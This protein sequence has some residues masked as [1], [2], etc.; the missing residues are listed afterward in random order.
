MD[1]PFITLW[2]DIACCVY[3]VRMND[4]PVMEDEGGM[5]LTVEL[6]INP[7]MI[8]GANS[9]SITLKPSGDEQLFVKDA[10]AEIKLKVR[11]KGAPKRESVEVTG[12]VFSDAHT[13][14]VSCIANSPPSGRF[15]SNRRFA[16]ADSGDVIVKDVR[17]SKVSPHGRILVSREINMKLP[18]PPWIWLDSRP[19]N[20]DKSTLDALADEYKKFWNLLNTRKVEEVHRLCN[21]MS[22]ELTTALF[23]SPI[24]SKSYLQIREMLEDNGIELYPWKP[25]GLSLHVFGNR[26]LARLVTTE[27]QSPIVFVTKARSAGYYFDLTYCR[28][29]KGWVICR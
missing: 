13:Q 10:R 16:A 14:N 19:I 27:G 4:V 11:P 29:G 1:K 6:P 24:E 20:D 28:T 22:D 3:S 12:I 2:I 18:F 26:R 15:D 23:L 21:V 7:Y 8:S 5:P 9:L 25:D 17:V